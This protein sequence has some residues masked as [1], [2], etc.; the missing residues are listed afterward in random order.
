[1]ITKEYKRGRK[2]ERV[3]NSEYIFI[4]IELFIISLYICEIY[5][6]NRNKAIVFCEEVI[7]RI[8]EDMFDNLA[9]QYYSE[10]KKVLSIIVEEDADIDLLH[11][12][13]TRVKTNSNLKNMDSSIFPLLSLEASQ[14]EK[15]S[16]KNNI[17]RVVKN[18]GPSDFVIDKKI[19][20]FQKNIELN[21]AK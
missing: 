8:H 13:F 4:V 21:K 9:L 6:E 1:M 10:Y 5:N 3:L 15:M 16:I 20:I 19:A 7:L 17:V 18:L 11:E 14:K 2:I 12:A